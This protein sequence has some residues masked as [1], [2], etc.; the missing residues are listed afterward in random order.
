MEAK[1]F[2]KLRE[3]LIQIIL[4]IRQYLCT[5]EFAPEPFTEPLDIDVLKIKFPNQI[6]DLFASKGACFPAPKKDIDK[7][8]DPLANYEIV[9]TLKEMMKNGR[10]KSIGHHR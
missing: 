10:Q 4:E 1:L 5:T 6:L 8:S 9:I 7:M 3:E 2:E